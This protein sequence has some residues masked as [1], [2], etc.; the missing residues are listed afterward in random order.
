MSIANFACCAGCVK[1]ANFPGARKSTQ[2]LLGV[3]LIPLGSWALS[4]IRD[5]RRTP[6]RTLEHNA[7]RNKQEDK[8]IAFVISPGTHVIK[9]RVEGARAVVDHKGPALDLGL[10]SGANLAS[11]GRYA[12]LAK[13]A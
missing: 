8:P 9:E 5:G 7:M 6:F 2:F 10:L 12:K 13:L 4:E 11:C 3:W 1:F